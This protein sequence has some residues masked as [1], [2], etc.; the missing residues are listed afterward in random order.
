MNLS[1][2]VIDVSSK[3]TIFYLDL[4]KAIMFGKTP[5][6]IAHKYWAAYNY[7][8]D[9]YETMGYSSLRYRDKMAKESIEATIRKMNPLDISVEVKGRIKS[10]KEEFLNHLSSENK[11]L[12]LK[13]EREY[14]YKLRNFNK[15][16]SQAQWR[17]KYSVYPF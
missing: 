14:R 8:V 12:A 2:P 6:E 1:E 10:K 15:I 11:T 3:R 7:L 9:E 4:K 5:Q 16:I 17:M 13:L